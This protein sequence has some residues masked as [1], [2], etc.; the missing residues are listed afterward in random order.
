[1]INGINCNVKYGYPDDIPGTPQNE[2]SV[3]EKKWMVLWDVPADIN[4]AI[5][6]LPNRIYCNREM[7]GP[8]VTAFLDI[9]HHGYEDQIITW[10]GCYNVRPIRGYE[11]RYQYLIDSND[12]AEALTYLSMHSWAIAFDI[13]AAWNRLG[14]VPTTSPELVGCF[15]R[16]GFLWGGNFH[17][18]DGMHYELQEI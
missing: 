11:Q 2:K 16:A 5:P 4:V 9:I 6:A 15:E 12:I 18:K 3:F 8:L 7:P 1:M 13:N 17:R 14:K 10:D